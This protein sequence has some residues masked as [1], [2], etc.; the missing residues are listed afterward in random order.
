MHI[1][2]WLFVGWALGRGGF[3]HGGSR[4]VLFVWDNIEKVL[5][6]VSV[7]EQ[8]MHVHMLVCMPAQQHMDTCI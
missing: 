4:L 6:F 8:H 1:K 2:V 5:F 3:P 7:V